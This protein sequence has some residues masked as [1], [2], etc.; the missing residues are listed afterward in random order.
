[1]KTFLHH[2]TS[3]FW[4]ILIF[5]YKKILNLQFLQK[6]LVSLK[7]LKIITF[8][9]KRSMKLCQ[10][11]IFLMKV[12]GQNI[13]NVI[14]TIKS[15]NH[16]HKDR[17]KVYLV[18]ERMIF[19][20]NNYLLQDDFPNNV[21]KFLSFKEMLQALDL[22]K[23][24]LEDDLLFSW[25]NPGDIFSYIAFEKLEKSLIEFKHGIFFYFDWIT[26]AGNDNRLSPILF[27]DSSNNLHF[28]I[29]YL[30]NSFLR[31]HK[32]DWDNFT[33]SIERFN[34]NYF[35]GLGGKYSESLVHITEYLC[36]RFDYS[37]NTPPIEAL[38]ELNKN[39]VSIK[40]EERV[41]HI[42]FDH[43]ISK[44]S[45]IIPSCDN[46]DL[47]RKCVNSILMSTTKENY[48][49]IILDNSF[50]DQQF[51]MNNALT[52]NEK[53]KIYRLSMKFNYSAFNNFGSKM[54]QG[55]NLIF[56]NDDI[57]IC[58]NDWLHEI[59]QWLDQP[60]V[61][62]VGGCLSFPDLTIQH[63]GIVIGMVGH[64]GNIFRNH[65]PRIN[66]SPFGP[67]NW[68]RNFYAVTGACLSIK[69]RL[70]DDVGGFNEDYQLVYSDVALGVEVNNAG[71]DVVYN[72]FIRMMHHEGKTRKQH[73]FTQDYQLFENKYRNILLDGDKF[74]NKNLSYLSF[75]PKIKYVSELSP[76]SRI[77]K[78]RR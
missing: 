42:F 33:Y 76:L 78:L 56:L 6:F 46:H 13:K 40:I 48:E 32:I 2:V 17:Y 8:D 68:Y 58:D 51:E 35:Y 39:I 73:V 65:D 27:P 72:P 7:T 60:K 49:V 67:I 28:S 53:V 22:M 52:F 55:D 21:E 1:M 45:I 63:A 54:A 34:E 19:S 36:V 75:D 74:Y 47:L 71:Y 23:N 31:I 50:S 20:E 29:N 15:I 64:A 70:F 16:I 11:Y 5:S 9:Q 59:I 24:K 57:E 25:I 3:W 12:D 38:K 30:E 44:T 14:E 4:Q 37:I 62:I 77:E 61:G 18:S 41:N 43:K 66:F 26:K 69:K 10:F